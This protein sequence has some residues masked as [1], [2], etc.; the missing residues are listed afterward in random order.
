M[1]LSAPSQ[2]DIRLDVEENYTCIVSLRRAFCTGLRRGRYIRA[3][4]ST[5]SIVRPVAARIQA[6]GDGA[7]PFAVVRDNR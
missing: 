4:P 5:I 3:D 2:L 1:A 7:L 6:E